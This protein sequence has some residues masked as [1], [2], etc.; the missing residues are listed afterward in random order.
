MQEWPPPFLCPHCTSIGY[1]I[2]A[3]LSTLAAQANDTRLAHYPPSLPSQ[4]CICGFSS[5]YSCW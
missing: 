5:N 4:S 2:W 1:H 3:T